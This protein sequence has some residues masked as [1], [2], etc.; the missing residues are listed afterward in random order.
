MTDHSA[1]TSRSRKPTGSVGARRES[2]F[3]RWIDKRNTGRNDHSLNYRNLY[4]F[5]TR[6]GFVFLLLAIILWVMGTNYQNNLIIAIAFFLVSLVVVVI[7]ATFFLLS[8]LRVRLE[9]VDLAEEQQA[10]KVQVLLESANPS[11][12]ICLMWQ[13]DARLSAASDLNAGEPRVV[14]LSVPVKSRGVFLLPR[15]L[16]QTEAPL[17]LV[18]C[19]TWLR[20][21]SRVWVYPAPQEFSRKE[22]F[23][24]AA[25]ESD[26]GALKQRHGDDFAGLTAYQPE[27]SMQRVAWKQLARGQGLLV[28]DFEQHIAPHFYLSPEGIDAPTREEQLAGISWWAEQL[29]ARAQAYGLK[30]G[31]TVVELDQGPMHLE[32]VRI[33]LAEAPG[34]ALSEEALL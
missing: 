4:I 9:Q 5:P 17:G 30:L 2:R 27:D 29:Q 23:E 28:K 3:F 21:S 15:L 31:S 16:V 24:D 1:A 6:R 22:V 7:H 20:F 13:N 33:A 32:R 34:A 12:G 19:W 8:G 26:L 14:E 18:R 11:R 25:P 10:A